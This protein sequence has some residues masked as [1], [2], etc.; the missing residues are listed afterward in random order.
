M[1]APPGPGS[2][3]SRQGTD[4]PVLVSSGRIVET[5]A[6]LTLSSTP[7]PQTFR[8]GAHRS[9]ELDGRRLA[10]SNMLPCGTA[11]KCPDGASALHDFGARAF[12]TGQVPE[13]GAS[14]VFPPKRESYNWRVTMSIRPRV[15]RWA[16]APFFL[17]AALLF[18]VVPQAAAASV[19]SYEV[20]SCYAPCGSGGMDT[21]GDLAQATTQIAAAG[22]STNQVAGVTAAGALAVAQQNVWGIVVLTGHAGPGFFT[23][24][25]GN[26]TGVVPPGYVGSS[27]WTYLKA[28]GNVGTCTSPDGCISYGYLTRVRLMLFQGCNSAMYYQNHYSTYYNLIYT[29]SAMGV[30][31]AVGF[32]DEIS[33]GTTT[34]R[35]FDYDFFYTLRNGSA[36]SHSLYVAVAYVGSVN[37]GNYAGYISYAYTGDTTIVPPALGV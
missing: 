19:K 26:V 21:R 3:V 6:Q 5:R 30:D 24:Y 35:A 8:F 20:G 9:D 33:F 14:S 34:G 10:G 32:Q 15:A 37:G 23:T 18:S 25:A 11:K 22:Y 1:A 17:A 16:W 28:S 29:A 27:G 7:G 13:R 31:S 12:R 2:T 36:V 4:H